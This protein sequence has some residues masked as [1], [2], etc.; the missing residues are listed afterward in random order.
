M[1]TGS[2]W[3]KKI[4]LTLCCW[5]IS[6]GLSAQ[7][8]QRGQYELPL[9]DQEASK[10]NITG[11]RESGLV[12]YRQI[13]G[14]EN[15]Q[16]EVIRLDTAFQ[17]IWKVYIDVNKSQSLLHVDQHADSLFLLFKD[18]IY[19]G[20]DFQL[21]SMRLGN[22]DYVIH[23]IKNLIPF[24]PSEFI[25]TQKAAWIGGYYNYRPIVLH[26][27]FSK[28]RSRVL[29]GFFNSP[30]E[31]DQLTSDASGNI[32]VIVSARNLEKRKSLWIRNYDSEGELIKT[33]IV[34]PEENKNLLFGRSTHLEDGDQIVAGVYG[35]FT[36]YSRGIFIAN[37]NPIGEYSIGY[38][39]FSELHNFFTYMKSG[40]Q[41]R[42][43]E[44]IERKNTEGKKIKFNY[45]FLIHDIIPYQG[46]FI[47]TGE[48][49]YPHFH[50]SSMTYSSGFQNA[51]TSTGQA[52]SFSSV[53]GRSNLIFDF[54]QYTHAVVIGI[55]KNGNIL[56]DNSF[57][58]NDARSKQ[59]GQFVKVKA[60]KDRIVM[61]YL[62]ENT[63]RSKVIKGSEVLAGKTLVAL[64]ASSDGDAVDSR[65]S[66]NESLDHWYGDNFYASGVRRVSHKAG[67]WQ[68]VFFIS[69]IA[70]K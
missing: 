26:F 30:G 4:G 1:S 13:S 22:G 41:K 64:K 8:V 43:K 3:N 48:A 17:E 46:Q 59:L 33:T 18:R 27:S 29:A 52:N 20:G 5:F 2:R 16:L 19:L 53:P 21:A 38:H 58:I 45:R 54:Y 15:D 57:E 31:L 23:N 47:M 66:E 9:I 62:F 51:F 68:K 24:N 40:R 10:F 69:K 63:L 25:V 65:S 60:E 35:R 7:I 49:F 36:D 39:N 50:Y 70:Y 67:P 28:A 61:L 55:D 44:R 11:L 12:F 14:R 6:L 56:W 32:E 34:R 42:I 37:I